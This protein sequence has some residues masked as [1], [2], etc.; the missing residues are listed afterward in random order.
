MWWVFYTLARRS[1]VCILFFI[2]FGL[3]RCF[4]APTTPTHENGYLEKV[5]RYPTPQWSCIKNF[6]R[7][8]SLKF[9]DKTYKDNGWSVFIP[10]SFGQFDLTFLRLNYIHH[11]QKCFTF[12]H[13]YAANFWHFI[14]IIMHFHSFLL[15]FFRVESILLSLL[16]APWRPV[17]SSF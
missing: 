14:Y 4:W 13:K 9:V 7:S 8:I 2:L 6:F 5:E 3:S 11:P 12:I 1:R 17:T 15:C 16:I 10:L